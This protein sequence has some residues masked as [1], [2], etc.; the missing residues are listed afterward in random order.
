MQDLLYK[1]KGEVEEMMNISFF[2]LYRII[3]LLHLSRLQQYEPHIL[4]LK[5]HDDL[6][7]TF[8][9]SLMG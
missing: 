8:D 1:I 7:V 6:L 3:K 5:L 4:W 2:I 9:F